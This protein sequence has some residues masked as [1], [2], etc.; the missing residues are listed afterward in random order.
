MDLVAVG[1]YLELFLSME[2]KFLIH[3]NAVRTMT[4]YVVNK[5]G[6]KYTP[7][8]N[9]KQYELYFLEIYFAALTC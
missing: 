6:T 9:L 8:S 4:H 1:K 7:F 5:D 2:E 3:L